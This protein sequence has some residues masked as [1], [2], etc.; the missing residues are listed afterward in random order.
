MREISRKNLSDEVYD[1]LKEMIVTGKLKPGEK[2][3]EEELTKNLGVSRT[4]I[5]QAISALAQDNLVNIVPRRGAFV[6]SL[7]KHDINEIYDIRMVLEGLAI[8]LSVQRLSDAQ[9]DKM[10]RVMEE[11]EAVLE[12]NPEKAIDADLMLHE[13][14]VKNC[15]NL[16]L[17]EIISELRDQVH[18]FRILE[19]HQPEVIPKVMEERWNILNAIKKRD[20]DQAERAIARHIEAVKERRLAQFSDEKD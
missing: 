4:P 2:L 10:T 14:I 6:T 13:M 20:P 9:L 11:A 1:V 12:E 18:S 3:P 7:S 5:R 16:R 17:Q 15:G 19:G 8:R